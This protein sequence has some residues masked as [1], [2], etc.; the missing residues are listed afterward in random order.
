MKHKS[1]FL[2]LV[3]RNFFFGDLVVTIYS[4]L[5][6]SENL[7]LLIALIFRDDLWQTF[8]IPKNTSNHMKL[9][10]YRAMKTEV[11][12]TKEWI[13]P[14][15][16]WKEYSPWKYPDGSA[17]WVCTSC[18]G[19]EQSNPFDFCSLLLHLH[20]RGCERNGVKKHFNIKVLFSYSRKQINWN[21]KKS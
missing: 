13:T 14:A 7:R 12:S 6:R 3:L 10:S 15:S 9:L 11:I 2:L 5:W 19:K 18:D 17:F 16:S 8:L 4:F 21:K 20:T 1:G